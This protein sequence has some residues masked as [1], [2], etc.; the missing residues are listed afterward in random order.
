MTSL[1][2][3]KIQKPE[4]ESPLIISAGTLDSFGEAEVTASVPPP[5]AGGADDEVGGAGEIGG[6]GEA[7]EACETGGAGEVGGA[8]E[9][10]VSVPAAADSGAS[11]ERRGTLA[12]ARVEPEGSL[13]VTSQQVGRA[14]AVEVTAAGQDGVG[15]PTGP[16]LGAGGVG[17]RP[18]VAVVVPQ[19]A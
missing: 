17:A 7:G 2:T 16:D 12:G 10:G 3:A 14:V 8:C 9:L 11:G 19:R 6:T 4:S 1:K 5:C 15:V 13:W 18:D